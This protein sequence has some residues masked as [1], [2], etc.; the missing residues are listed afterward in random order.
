VKP[1]FFKNAFFCATFAMFAAVVGGL[2]GYSRFFPDARAVE[3]MAD[4]KK[5]PEELAGVGVKEHLGDTLPLSSIEVIDSL[6]GEKRLLSSYFQTGKPVVMNLVYYECPM[7]CTM[8]LNGV[9]EGLKKLGWSVGREFNV[10]TISINPNDTP[11][12]ARAKKENYLKDYAKSG[13]NIELAREGWSFLT[14][15]EDQVRNLASRL[16]FEYKYDEI[17]KQYAHS[18][19][20]FV[21]TPSGVISRYLYGIVYEPKNLKLGLLEASQ[22]KIGSVFDRLLM[23]CYHY[24][25]LARGYSLQAMKVMQLGAMAFMAMMCGYLMVFWTRQRKGKLK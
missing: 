8:V 16:G 24:E 22:G 18:A 2:D 1:H 25:P 4:P 19:V 10:V 13:H 9:N 7:L 3:L 12:M 23:F 20:T 17:Q 5:A 11:A 21:L 14:A 15:R 6:N